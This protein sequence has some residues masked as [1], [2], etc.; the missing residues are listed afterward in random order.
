VRG[1]PDQEDASRPP[2]W[3]G[4]LVDRA[5]VELIVTLQ[6]GEG[7]GRRS[8]EVGEE[9]AEVGQPALRW[10]PNGLGSISCW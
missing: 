7:L 1:V 8:W 9:G 10:L 5:K 6:A 3:L 4:H 2:A